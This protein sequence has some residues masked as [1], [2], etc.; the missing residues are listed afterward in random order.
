MIL[1][2][3]V[4]KLG[5]RESAVDYTGSNTV[6]ITYE[7]LWTCNRR[8]SAEYSPERVSQL[9]NA[10]RPILLSSHGIP[11]LCCESTCTPP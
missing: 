7:R 6:T 4:S 8:S 3:R 9:D 1:K 5:G 10:L 2:L 11:H